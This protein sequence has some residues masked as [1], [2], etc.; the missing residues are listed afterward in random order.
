M[1]SMVEGRL[2]ALR[3]PTTTACG[4]GPPP[5]VRGGVQPLIPSSAIR[6]PSGSSTGRRLSRP[7]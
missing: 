1:R 2:G 6:H 7:T 4:G 3:S 5:R